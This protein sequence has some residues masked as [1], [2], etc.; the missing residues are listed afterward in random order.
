MLVCHRGAP[1][2]CALAVEKFYSKLQFLDPPSACDVLSYCI[3][4]S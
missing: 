4:N 3:G 2:K 1:L